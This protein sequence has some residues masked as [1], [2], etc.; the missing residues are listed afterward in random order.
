MSLVS[1]F[2]FQKNDILFIP[3]NYCCESDHDYPDIED[4]KRESSE[5]I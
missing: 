1:E 5:D 2:D 3:Q 4:D